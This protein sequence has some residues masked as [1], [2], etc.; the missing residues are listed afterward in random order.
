MSNAFSWV[1]GLYMGRCGIEEI[2]DVDKKVVLYALGHPRICRVN[3]F[4]CQISS[5]KLLVWPLAVREYS[6]RRHWKISGAGRVLAPGGG[7]VP[8][9]GLD[10]FRQAVLAGA[11]GGRTP[12]HELVRCFN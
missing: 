7:Q 8:P 1:H 5:R 3:H 6:A 12:G 9:G 10:L 11:P 2:T 4:G